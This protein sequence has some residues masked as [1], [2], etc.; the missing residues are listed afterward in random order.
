MC[1]L[2]PEQTNSILQPQQDLIRLVNQGQSLTIAPQ[3]GA[4]ITHMTLEKEGRQV[5]VL[6]PHEKYLYENAWLFPF[7][8][9]LNKGAYGFEGKSYQ[10]PIN[11]IDLPNALHGFV[12][13]NAFE[14]VTQTD[15]HC[16]L[17]YQYDGRHEFYP[18]PFVLNVAYSLKE[19]GL[20]LTAR[21]KNTGASNLPSGLGWH[22]Y[23]HIEK[24]VA[25]AGLKIPSCYEV[26]VDENLIPTGAKRPSHCFEEFSTLKDSVLD[27]C[28]E[29]GRKGEQQSV[30]LRLEEGLILEV[31][32]DA[33]YPYVQ[34]FTPKDRQ[35]I[36]IEPVT[37]A[38]DAFN[39]REGLKI[40][41]PGESWEVQCGVRLV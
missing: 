26:E 5:Q 35:T 38:I 8:N 31:W 16:E 29:L 27:T 32:Q 6:Q 19:D 4:V 7:P 28:F 18:F 12:H 30:E 21:V 14:L 22:P 1:T 34:V 9:R 13:G 33:H 40:L 24:G 36:A 2:T 25:Q 17:T 11:D 10:F 41:S 23:F 39:S 37:C 20:Y 3:N 15:D